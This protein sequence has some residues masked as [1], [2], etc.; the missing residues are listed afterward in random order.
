MKTFKTILSIFTIISMASCGV[1][2]ITSCGSENSDS[3]T[4]DLNG[5]WSGTAQDNIAGTGNFKATLSQSGSTVTGTWYISFPAV[6][7]DNAGQ[8]SGRIN[9]TSVSAT[10]TPSDPDAC[11]FKLTANISGKQMSGTYA[12]FNCTGVIAGTFNATKQ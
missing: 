7:Y 2:I 1:I 5:T 9:G 4:V 11:P 12:S 3:N 6:E 8:V 10:L